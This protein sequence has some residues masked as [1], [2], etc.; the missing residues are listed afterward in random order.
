MIETI[1]IIFMILF[2]FGLTIFVHEWGHF[3]VAR[4][5]GLK[6]EA[7]A[8]GMGP[9]LIQKKYNDV[10]YKVCI[11]PIGGYVSLPQLDP[12]GMEKLQGSNNP[13]DILPDI[14]P[15]KKIAVA[16]AGP[17]CNVIFALLLGWIVSF[18]NHEEIPAI[19]GKVVKESEAY[20]LGLRPSDKIIKVNNNDVNSWYDVQVEA[21][22]S[23]S[24]SK[25]DVTVLRNGTTNLIQ[26]IKTNN[27]EKNYI[28]INGVTEAIPCIVGDVIS[29]DPAD[30]A[31]LITN[32]KIKKINN[33][34]IHDWNHFT[35]TLQNY[36]D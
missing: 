18:G 30:I 14:S 4:K 36:P 20:K 29:G 22:L 33:K 25:I 9:A 24:E 2:L 35:D 12:N 32:D 13:D 15:W 34:V 27:P 10:L 28:F 16:F 3:I 23:N 17:I 19:I 11:F 6:V 1:Y 7:F 26:N 5:C 21:L 31:G 8:I